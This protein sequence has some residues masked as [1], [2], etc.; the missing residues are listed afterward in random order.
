MT[1]V[2]EW[3]I[4]QRYRRRQSFGEELAN[5]VSHGLGLLGAIAVTPVLVG[6][7]IER[8]DVA[9]VVG[10]SVFCVA[11]AF[12]YLSSSLYH[13]LPLG[14]AKRVVRRCDHAAIYMLIAGTYTPFTLG[15]LRGPWGW[16]LF[17]MVWTLAI[18][19]LF[20]ESR[21]HLRIMEGATSEPGGF[22]ERFKPPGSQSRA[23][24]ATRRLSIAIY[25]A[26]GWL[27][28]IAVGPIWHA[29]STAGLFWI[30]AGGLSYMVGLTFYAASGVRYAHLAWH[31]CVL[32]GSAC[33]FLA[34]L[35][36]S[37]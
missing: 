4:L 10:N 37:Y 24:Q 29:V 3:V 23:R 33:F 34:V 26:M 25:L 8:D 35:W 16:T 7:A 28:L 22:S 27:A 2:R 32:V 21:V 11:M 12:L 18:L 5:S 14:R 36:Y 31:L 20:V 9:A 30:V 13:A 1:C 6:R 19:G 15:V 17:G